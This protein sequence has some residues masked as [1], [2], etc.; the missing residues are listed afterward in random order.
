[1]NLTETDTLLNVMANVDNRKV[2]DATVLVWHEILGDLPFSDC[3]MAV[4]RHFGES[5]EYLMPVHIVRGAQ[6]IERDRI[7]AAN[8]RK[9][10]EAAPETD[11]RPLT[12]RS[13]EIRDF[14]NGIHSALPEGDPDALR[15][16]HKHWRQTREGRERQERAE[17]NPHYDPSAQAALLYVDPPLT[18]EEASAIKQQWLERFG[19]NN[20]PSRT[21]TEGQP[22]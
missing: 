11:S 20:L 2:D 14:V 13:K 22:S 7:R 9:E 21:T 1:M 19:K 18:A 6:A 10:L 16:G 4:T 3:L 15:W 17:P 12:D 8:H 5:G